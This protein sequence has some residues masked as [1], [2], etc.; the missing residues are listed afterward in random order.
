[1]MVPSDKDWRNMWLVVLA[2]LVLAL[3]VSGGLGVLLGWLVARS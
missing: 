3:L 2:A 1:M